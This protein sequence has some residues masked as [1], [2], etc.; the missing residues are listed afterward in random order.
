VEHSWLDLFTNW[1]VPPLASAS[2]ALVAVLYTVG[3]NRGRK[4]RPRELSR[5]RM[6]AFLSG[7]LSIFVAIA[8][9]LDTLSESILFMHM[10]QHFVLMSIAPP[11]IV[12]GAP[13]VPLLRAFPR[14]LIRTCLGPLIASRG[15]RSLLR[16]VTRPSISWMAMNAAYVGWHIPSAYEFALRSEGWHNVEHVCFLFSSILF[17]WPVIRPWPCHQH[18][19]QLSAVPYLLGADI[20]NTG[21]SALL[22]F[23]GRVIYPSYASA[24]PPLP[25]S[26][27]NDQ[28]AAGAFM[29][30]FGS[31]VFLLPVAAIIM[32]V[33]SPRGT[34]RPS[35][36][37]SG[38]ISAEQL[39][40]FEQKAV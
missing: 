7:V 20:V 27:L 10:A 23:S 16:I 3:W 30:V 34:S 18:P 28:A 29:W 32:Q 24:D 1:D 2:L 36:T 13:V 17:W 35:P 37:A 11:L 12:L 14:P 5:W 31:L 22:C 26:P 25:I 8:S 15:V 40:Y 39:P 33:L 9:P 38:A 19:L 21:V 4:T 6:V